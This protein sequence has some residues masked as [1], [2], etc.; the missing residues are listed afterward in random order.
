MAMP[1][2]VEALLALAAAPR[3]RLGA[4]AYN[5]GAF[6]PTAEEIRDV[7]ARA[8]PG[9][10][11]SWDTDLKRQASSTRGRPTSTTPPRAATG[12]SHPRYDFD[13]RVQRVSD[14]DDQAALRPRTDGLTI[15]D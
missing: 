3:E 9:A 12:A 8:F 10:R 13:A 5:V 4:T 14:P 11:L 1:D 15:D 2:G 7:V 6:S